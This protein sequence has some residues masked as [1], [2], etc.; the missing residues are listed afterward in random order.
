MYIITADGVEYVVD[1]GKKVYNKV[2]SSKEDLTEPP[3]K[4]GAYGV[5][6]LEADAEWLPWKDWLLLTF[7][8][9]GDFY[10]Y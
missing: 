9:I 5:R 10:N 7:K 8:N 6:P 4:N 3:A 1:A 2:A